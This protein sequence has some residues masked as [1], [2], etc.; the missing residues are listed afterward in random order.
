MLSYFLMD[1]FG[2]GAA[3][4]GVAFTIVGV[5][6]TLLQG[7]VVG[8]V[9]RG[10][11][12]F[13]AIQGGLCLAALGYLAIA[14][15]PSPASFFGAVVLASAGMG[16]S[17]SPPL[18]RVT[19]LPQGATMGLVTSSDS[20]GRMLG[21]LWAGVAFGFAVGGPY[22]SVAGVVLAGLVAFRLFLAAESGKIPPAVTYPVR[23][24]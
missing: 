20:L 1:R 24:G 5:T 19:T 7:L 17:P 8:R 3:E 18:S 6:I 2:G 9:I 16:P 21:P 14:L 22:Y 4:A 10:A 11:G 12:E 13:R 15:A 23:D